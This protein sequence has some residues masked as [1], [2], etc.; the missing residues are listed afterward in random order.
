MRRIYNKIRRLKGSPYLGRPGVTD[1]IREVPVPPLP[2]DAIYR[3]IGATV[4]VLRAF[5]GAQS[6]Q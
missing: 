6:R 1:R 4:E 3:V 5:Q 2:F